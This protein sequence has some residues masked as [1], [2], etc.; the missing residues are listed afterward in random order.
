MLR[1]ATPVRPSNLDMHADAPQDVPRRSTQV[2]A[3]PLAHERILSHGAELLH[4][5]LPQ[6]AWVCRRT[7]RNTSSQRYPR[8]SRP[9]T[10]YELSRRSSGSRSPSSTT[11]YTALREKEAAARKAMRRPHATLARS[12]S[13]H[14][15]PPHVVPT[16]AAQKE[17]NA[18][19]QN[20]ACSVLAPQQPAKMMPSANHHDVQH[21]Q[22]AHP[23][24]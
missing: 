24:A 4:A 2:Q 13:S 5:A 23:Q 14:E 16:L 21:A 1:E 10:A 17:R 12:H 15:D 22:R 6:C 8:C 20:R 11:P 9:H 3:S 7:S 19:T 18:R